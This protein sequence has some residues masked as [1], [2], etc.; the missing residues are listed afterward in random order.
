MENSTIKTLLI[1]ILI[2]VV[3]VGLSMWRTSTTMDLV[4]AKQFDIY[5]IDKT[6]ALQAKDNEF[7][8]SKLE[9]INRKIEELKGMIQELSDKSE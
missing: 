1:T 8:L 3:I 7:I 6:L 5:R 9:E 2:P 4:Y